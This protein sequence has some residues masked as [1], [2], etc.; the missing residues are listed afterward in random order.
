MIKNIISIIG[1]RP[2][3]MKM[4]PV[5]NSLK[6]L[7]VNNIVVHTG[8]HYDQKMS[9]DILSDLGFQN[10]EYFLGAGGGTQVNQIYKIMKRF[11][12]VC[13]KVKPV[14]VIV[15][16]DVNSTLA[17]ALVAAKMNIKVAHVEAGLRSDDLGMPEEINRILTDRLSELLFTTEMNA[18]KNLI[19]EGI[20]SEKIHFV[21]N[22]MIDSVNKFIS[23]AKNLKFWNNLGF[24]KKEYLLA[25][26]HRPSNVDSKN[27]LSNV[28]NILNV[29][30]KKLPIVFPIH[31]RTRKKLDEFSLKLN[32]TTMLLEPLS[33]I[34]FLSLMSESKIILTDSGGIQ[35]EATFL[36]VPCITMRENTERPITTEIGTNILAGT[37]HENIISIF[38]K[39]MESEEFKFQIP[40][41]WDGHTGDRI[42]KI[43]KE[44][45]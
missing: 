12:E 37:E 29:I 24:N 26:I 21:G 1:A 27:D 19:N 31:P 18:A 11:E 35:E 16:G 22:C 45:I 20:S 10:P 38:D 17:C 44:I 34:P 33:Y 2:N 14:L 3:F 4:A 32:K 15:A 7:S 39:I 28:V 41:L 5:I 30:S 8:Q 36:G 42:V 25:T 40:P 43:I 23:K 6:T 9:E 13:L